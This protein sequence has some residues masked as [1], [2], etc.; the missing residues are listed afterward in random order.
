MHFGRFQMSME[1]TYVV[2][3]E[4]RSNIQD[5]L[6]FESA[7]FTGSTAFSSACGKVLQLR[8]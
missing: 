8:T 3:I 2:P 5:C 1:I 7:D 6:S 4:W